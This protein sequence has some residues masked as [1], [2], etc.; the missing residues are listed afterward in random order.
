[1]T[2]PTS[3]APLD[4]EAADDLLKQA[5]FAIWGKRFPEAIA[6][7]E[8][9]CQHAVESC[10]RDYAKA[11]MWLVKAYRGNGQMED[12]IALCQTLM[13]SPDEATQIWAVQ[14]LK[15]LQPETEG[16]IE[17]DGAVVENAAEVAPLNSSVQQQVF[18][19]RDTTSDEPQE[20]LMAGRMALRQGRYGDA[21]ATLQTFCQNN[22][23]GTEEYLQ[24]QVWLAKA[25]KG[26]GQPQIALELCQQLTLATAQN[27]RT[28]AEQFLQQLP[29]PES[30]SQSESDPEPTDLPSIELKNLAELRR[31]YQQELSRDLAKLE[32]Q[33]K[34][35]MQANVVVGLILV[36]TLF[37]L[38]VIMVGRDLRALTT[39]RDSIL[40]AMMHLVPVF[41]FLFVFLLGLWLWVGFFCHSIDTYGAGFKSKVIQKIIRFIDANKILKYVPQGQSQAIATA[42][43]DSQLFHETP[44]HVAQD[45]RVTGKMGST[46]ICFA[47]I[48]AEAKIGEGQGTQQSLYTYAVGESESRS[49]VDT[50]VVYTLSLAWRSLRGSFYILS[51][52][53]RGQ[54]IRLEHFN[55]DIMAGKIIRR[56]IFKG[57]F[58]VADFHKS[59]QGITTV[60]P[61]HTERF[62]GHV[63]QDFQS[64]NQR[65]GQL[66]RLEDPEFEKLFAVYSTDQIEAR[67]LLSTRL[68]QKLVDFTRQMRRDTSISF[69]NDKI[70]IAI[71]FDEDLFEPKLFTPMDFTPVREYFDTLQLMIGIVEELKLNRRIW[72][73]R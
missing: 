9:Y 45:D 22:A 32:Q 58:F 48:I 3:P 15:T 52:L 72:M 31:F 29:L 16:E 56:Q 70:Y 38:F 35:T 36:F 25:Y 23:P 11:Q 39:T 1:M 7:L 43:I 40:E 63:A 62:L 13:N 65:Q 4:T 51:R 24:A 5:N 20:G 54:R 33:R 59:F 18:E 26:N 53:L 41:G 34:V 28:W 30:Q 42:F 46:E 47:E 49:G 57:L 10:D 73:K 71:H 27:V 8:T 67:Y 44:N 66:V 37:V 55:S 68:M 2:S 6:A 21:I 50:A 61:D 19:G 12:A 64:L 14:Y 60:V 69:V 17:T